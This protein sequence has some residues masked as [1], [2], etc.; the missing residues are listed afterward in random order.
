MKMQLDCVPCFLR[1]ALEASR[2]VTDNP[3]LQTKILKEA[4]AVIERFDS[5]KSAP[6]MGRAVHGIVKKLTGVTDPYRQIKQNNL[7]LA[8]HYYPT[9]KHYLFRRGSGLDLVLKIA[10]IGNNL[11]AAI[12]QEV[13]DVGLLDRELDKGFAICDHKRWEERLKNAKTL[14]IIGDN[15]GETVFDRVLIEQLLYL[16][17][18]YAVRSGPIINDATLDDAV[19]ARLDRCARVIST[20]CDS[21]GLLLNECSAEFLEIYQQA[22]L[23][24]SKGQGNYETLSETAGREIFFLLKAKCPIIAKYLNVAV[25]D[26]I[27]KFLN[28]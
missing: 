18:T 3:E 2:I 23:V 25:G 21:P 26:Y 1:Q 4:L 27:F 20:G 12:Y 16:D 11:D 10:A 13:T 22:D 17:V 9:L 6:E 8:E 7:K 5:Y 15:A 14:L 19:S 28:Q 24:I